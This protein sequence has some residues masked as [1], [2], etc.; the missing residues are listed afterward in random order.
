MTV[1]RETDQASERVCVHQQDRESEYSRSK[2]MYI[3][4]ALIV[5]VTIAQS[6]AFR[7]Q[8]GTHGVWHGVAGCQDT[9]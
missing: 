4:E 3:L 8:H 1:A 5:I 6:S 2:V 9:E 7:F